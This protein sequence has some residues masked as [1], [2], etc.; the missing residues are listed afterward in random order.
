M[1]SRIRASYLFPLAAAATLWVV[2]QPTSARQDDPPPPASC[3]TC[4]ADLEYCSC[5]NSMEGPGTCEGFP[6][7]P[8]RTCVIV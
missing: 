2:A 7:C 5:G 4:N 3:C 1:F 6:P 8:P